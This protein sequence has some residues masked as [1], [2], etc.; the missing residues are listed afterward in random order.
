MIKTKRLLAG[1]TEDRELYFIETSITDRN[2]HDE[3]TMSGFTVL[4]I[5]EEEKEEKE[6]SYLDGEEQYYW[7]EA[8]ASGSTFDSMDDWVQQ[9]RDEG[10]HVDCSLYPKTADVEGIT[11]YFESQGCGQHTVYHLDY[12]SISKTVHREMITLWDKYHLKPTSTMIP[13]DKKLLD[14][15][16]DR[17]QDEEAEV[18]KAVKYIINN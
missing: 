4:P 13:E 10:D 12:Y 8:V 16:M 2:G 6:E 5:T 1:V 18:I 3:L 9:V 11:Y 14:E 15:I 17:E 7:Q